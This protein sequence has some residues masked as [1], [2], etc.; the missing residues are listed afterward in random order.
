MYKLCMLKTRRT[1]R[2]HQ[3][4][5]L[6]KLLYHPLDSQECGKTNRQSKSMNSLNDRYT[7]HSNV[8]KQTT[9]LYSQYGAA[10]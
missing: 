1:A 8:H 4:L 7:N 2:T 6:N 3:H 9:S 10:G 5:P